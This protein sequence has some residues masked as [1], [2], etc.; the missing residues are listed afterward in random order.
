MSVSHILSHEL[1]SLLLWALC[2]AF[3][4]SFESL[5]IPT[6]ITTSSTDDDSSLDEARV[7]LFLL[8]DDMFVPLCARRIRL[9]SESSSLNVVLSCVMSVR[10]VIIL[11]LS[12]VKELNTVSAV[13][14]RFACSVWNVFRSR[15]ISS[16]F[17]FRSARPDNA[18]SSQ[19]G[20][21]D[22]FPLSSCLPELMVAVSFPMLLSAQVTWPWRD[23][24]D[25]V[26]AV[27]LSAL[28]LLCRAYSLWPGIA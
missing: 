6:L 18:P 19:G 2:L 22:L 3:H 25:S 28:L 20:T 27:E 17:L 21:C 9:K 4:L 26:A 10:I 14:E 23:E 12:L 8:G 13:S 5:P 15:S 16:I 11:S 24:F 1:E 7:T